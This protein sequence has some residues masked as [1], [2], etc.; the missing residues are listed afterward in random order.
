MKPE[1]NLSSP[2]RYDTMSFKAIWA[3]NTPYSK[4]LI[5]VGIIL[6]SA[7]FFTII[8]TVLASII[9]GVD[10]AQ[11]ATLMTNLENPSNIKVLKMMQTVSAIGTFIVPPFI[12]A[13]LFHPA[14]LS[15][16]SIDK[17]P[18]G[19]ASFMIIAMLMLAIPF[20][21]HLGELNSYFHLPSILK[22]V[23]DWMK[24]SE[25]QAAKITEAFLIMTNP[26]EL[27]FNL[28]M[29]ALI[30]AIGEELL[31]RGIVQN[32]FSRWLK[33][34]HAAVW[35]SAILFSAMHMQFYGFIP[36]LM[37]G[38]MLGYLLVWSGNIWWPILAHFVNNAAAVIFTYLF[39]NN[40]S[41]FNPDTIGVGADQVI[42]VMLSLA[43][44]A[45]LLFLLHK[46]GRKNR[47][48]S[49]E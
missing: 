2:Q 16:L 31:F 14:P 41:S 23:E 33:N 40:L 1:E 44:T 39:Q 13:W 32:I 9:F 12:L 17:K 26:S 10:T 24:T 47:L 45:I 29:I 18:A 8:G 11:L 30:P 37:L 36:R 7:V 20:I 22:G 46:E 28:F 5:S 15:F 25:E 38:V 6:I 19:L 48:L 4:F 35:L 43:F 49:E 3:N 27:V 42:T 34:N 21:N